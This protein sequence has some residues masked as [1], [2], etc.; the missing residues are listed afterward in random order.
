MK[1]FS[2]NYS[3]YWEIIYKYKVIECGYCLPEM[4]YSVRK[5]YEWIKAQQ[6]MTNAVL[7]IVHNVH[8][9]RVVEFPYNTVVLPDYTAY[10][11]MKKF[12]ITRLIRS[13]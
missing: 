3:M 5:L 1:Q 4:E 8:K 2:G 11:N 6:G 9:M 13:I 12:T 7:H 10:L